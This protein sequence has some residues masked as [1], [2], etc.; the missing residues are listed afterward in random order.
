[1]ARGGGRSPAAGRGDHRERNQRHGGHEQRRGQ[2]AA[3]ESSALLGA[4]GG[5]LRREEGH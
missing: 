3:P 4:P 2:A 1:M 5:D